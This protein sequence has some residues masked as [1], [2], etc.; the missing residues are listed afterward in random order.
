MKRQE[1]R[2]TE[3]DG[4]SLDTSGT[5]EERPEPADEPIAYCQTGRPPASSAQDDQLLLE[6]E[7]LRITARTPPGPQSFAV[8]TV[9]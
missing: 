4:D 5:E 1:R 9:R 2:G 8:M 3:G 6:Q 7:I